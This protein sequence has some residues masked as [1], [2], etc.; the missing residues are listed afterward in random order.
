MVGGPRRSRVHRWATGVAVLS[1]MQ[2]ACAQQ[3]VDCA[4][5]EAAHKGEGTYYTWADGTGACGFDAVHGEPL[6]A[7]MNHADYAA[8]AACG[9]CVHAV[10][11]K[12]EV[13]VQIVD[14]CPGCSRGDLDFSPQAFERVARMA[15]GRVPITWRY[16]P[17]PVS[18]PIR[19]HFKEG[20][21]R[22]WTA[23]QV[24]NH[25]HRIQ[26]LSWRKA[27]GTLEAIE[28]EDYN[29]FV[30]RNGMGVGPYELHVDDVYGNALV[31]RE[32]PLRTNG[33]S[34]GSAQFPAC[35]QE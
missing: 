16:V 26:A 3:G 24:R 32:V 17:C 9:A 1:G 10:G 4:T 23:V 34:D 15:D 21:S 19:Y 31:D 6:V 22:W 13:D 18:G 30:V 35:Q 14:E 33:D 29:Y 28:R 20:S 8:S 25:R 27:D 2:L 11:P 7:A 5:Q 12:G